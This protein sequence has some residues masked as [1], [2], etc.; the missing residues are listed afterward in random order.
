MVFRSKPSSGS[1]NNGDREFDICDS[2]PSSPNRNAAFSLL[3]PE[4]G[5][6][7]DFRNGDVDCGEAVLIL[8]PPDARE[9]ASSIHAKD[10][11][12]MV[13]LVGTGAFG[14]RGFAF[15]SD[16]DGV[17]GGLGVSALGLSVLTALA[18]LRSSKRGVPGS[19]FL[20]NFDFASSSGT[21]G[22]GLDNSGFLWATKVGLDPGIR[23]EALGVINSV[24]SGIVESS[25]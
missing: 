14:R 7:P 11:F 5:F 16:S 17:T 4:V 12:A 23:G 25:R 1:V 18:A 6:L 20:P 13:D 3:A 9:S 24:G 10:E 22:D 8:R 21:N 2:P 15:A 19:C